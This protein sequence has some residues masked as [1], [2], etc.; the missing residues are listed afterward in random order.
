MWVNYSRLGYETGIL[1]ERMLREEVFSPMFKGNPGQA[2]WDATGRFWTSTTRLNRQGRKFAQIASSEF[3]K[4]KLE[5]RASI[6]AAERQPNPKAG[7]AYRA[8]RWSALASIAAGGAIG[9]LIGRHRFAHR[10]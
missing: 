10:R 4:A 1:T 8:Q 7:R 2:W 3:H 9:I 5:A 6:N